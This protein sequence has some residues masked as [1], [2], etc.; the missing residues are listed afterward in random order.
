MI[1]FI[2]EMISNRWIKV[3]ARGYISQ[4]KQTHLGILQ[5]GVLSVTLFLDSPPIG[6]KT[7]GPTGKR[8]VP[9]DAE[10]RDVEKWPKIIPKITQI[11]F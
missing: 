8:V 5:R 3:R 10:S 7:D 4:S 9:S 11:L 6:A 1:E 2:R